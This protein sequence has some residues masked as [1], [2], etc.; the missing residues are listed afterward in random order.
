MALSI[1]IREAERHSTEG[2]FIH[3]GRPGARGAQGSRYRW[4]NAQTVTSR[5]RFIRRGAPNTLDGDEPLAVRVETGV[6][7]ASVGS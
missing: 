6:S 3:A 7:L 2:T 5:A 1:T 4:T